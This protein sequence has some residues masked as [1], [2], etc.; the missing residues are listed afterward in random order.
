MIQ[1]GNAVTAGEGAD[2]FLDLRHADA[3][4]VFSVKGLM[5]KASLDAP[6]NPRGWADLK[7]LFPQYFDGDTIL[8]RWT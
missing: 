2:L 5:H 7:Q 3:A 1:V 4:G 8:P 6:L